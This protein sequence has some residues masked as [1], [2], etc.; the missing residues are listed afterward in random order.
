MPI[1]HAQTPSSLTR[2]E[3]GICLVVPSEFGDIVVRGDEQVIRSLRFQP[4][5]VNQNIEKALWVDD[6]RQQLSRYCAGETVVFDLPIKPLGTVF[7]QAVWRALQTIPYGQLSSY[8]QLADALG[9]PGS[10]RAVASANARNPI[11][12]IIPCHRVIGSD[13]ALR[14]YAGGIETKARLLQL[15]GH[16]M[17]SGEVLKG[18]VSQ[19]TRVRSV[20]QQESLF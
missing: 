18:Q 3:G 20:S 9:N 5:Q 12:L 7:Q 14:G 17:E 4:G 13:R 10:V 15:E 11:S 19:K 2:Q 16:S 8:Q 6:C 1:L